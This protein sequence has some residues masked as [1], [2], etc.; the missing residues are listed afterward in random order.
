MYIIQQPMVRIETQGKDRSTWL[1][2]EIAQEVS[3]Y[4]QTQKWIFDQ[5]QSLGLK[6]LYLP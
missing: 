4:T 1:I 2:L 5:F 6:P 3:L